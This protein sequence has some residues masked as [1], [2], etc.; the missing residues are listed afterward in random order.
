MFCFVLFV[1]LSK[2]GTQK[3]RKW[4]SSDQAE[5]GI[6]SR[7]DMPG[8]NLLTIL[9]QKYRTKKKCLQAATWIIQ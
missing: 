4:P 7:T 2:I 6:I 8:G 1:D 3:T 5:Q 9:K